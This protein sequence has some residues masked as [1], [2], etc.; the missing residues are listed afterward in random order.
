MR[1]IENS[2][3]ELHLYKSNL[4]Q[5]LAEIIG[6]FDNLAREKHIHLSFQNRC[7]NALIAFDPDKM[8][9]IITNLLS[10]AFKH[11][12]EGGSIVV[13]LEKSSARQFK[14]IV[15]DTGKGISPQQLPH[16]FERYYSAEENQHSSGIGLSYIQELIQVHGGQIL[17]ESQECKGT[18]FSVFI[19]SDLN[20][21]QAVE[22]KVIEPEDL[23]IT[24]WEVQH[25][26]TLNGRKN[27]RFKS[28]NTVGEHL[29]RILIVEDNEDMADFLESILGRNYTVLKARN[30]NE[31]LLLAQNHPL[32][33][34][35]SD[36]M[37]PE[38]NGLDFCHH[39]KSDFKT[40][41][42]PVILLT[43]KKMEKDIIEGYVTGADDYMTK[44]FNP[45][46]LEIRVENLL[47]QREQLRTKF[48]RDFTLQPKAMTLTSPDEEL[49][50]RLVEIME[51]YI[52]DSDFNV[53]KMCE[54]VHLSHMHFIRKVKQLTGKKP[55]D[56]LKSYR[57]KRAKDVLQ[58]N[59]T[60]IAEV[61]Y[62]VGYDLP[63]SF[64]RAF[65][66]EFGFSPTEYLESIGQ[67]ASVG[68]AHGDN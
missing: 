65:K 16:I 39:I 55:I 31:G 68:Y 15:E 26:H 10:N 28:D 45:Q 23:Q 12:P 61:A 36:I 63:N 54:M 30:G 9:K 67:E 60:N 20:G 44:P 14:I 27:R 64:S 48:I 40:S 56:L 52:A 18:K 41:H 3:M 17:V 38:M 66:K 59:K 42:L 37:M 62:M 50:Q 29:P 6:L 2:S 4:G 35:V 24:H 51:E 47:N 57:L 34:I 1:R 33:L 43:A 46:L 8:E 13:I 53:N 32:D 21:T 25:L 22:K 5:F 11:T 7:E 49:L 19:P 58:Q